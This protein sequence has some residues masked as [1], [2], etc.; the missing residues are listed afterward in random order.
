MEIEN[1]TPNHDCRDTKRESIQKEFC[2]FHIGDN[3]YVLFNLF[4]GKLKVHIRKY[5]LEIYPTKKGITLDLKQFQT[6]SGE[7]YDR[8]NSHLAGCNTGTLTDFRFNLGNHIYITHNVQWRHKI[9]LR[10]WFIPKDTTEVLPTAKG[11]VLTFEQ[12]SNLK[13]AFMLIRQ[14][15]RNQ[16]ENLSAE[17]KLDTC[18]RCMCMEKHEIAGECR[19]STCENWGGCGRT[20]PN[21]M[22]CT[23]CD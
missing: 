17:Q 4:Q 3:H 2:K 10:Q 12:W 13:P 9:D 18:S 23:N 14:L 20:P 8:M 7:C 11:V 1:L 5:T 15:I 21:V 22:A 6:L 16:W 19:C